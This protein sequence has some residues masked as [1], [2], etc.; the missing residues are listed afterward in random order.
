MDDIDLTNLPPDIPITFLTNQNVNNSNGY[1]SNNINNLSKKRKKAIK[2]FN[3]SKYRKKLVK[4]NIYNNRDNND[5]NNDTDDNY[6]SN[7]SNINSNNTNSDEL[8]NI[9]NT[10]VDNPISPNTLS[11]N[12]SFFTGNNYYNGHR[13]YNGTGGG[14]YYRRKRYDGKIR[15]VYVN[16]MILNKKHLK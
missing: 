4:T 7:T 11:K 14:I 12:G 3:S 13:L 8:I 6:D 2:K 5:T 1:T 10:Y 15:K 9:S 16:K